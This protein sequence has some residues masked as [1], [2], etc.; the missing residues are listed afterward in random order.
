MFSLSRPP[1][2]GVCTV[3]LERP[4]ANAIGEADLDGL[5][6]LLEDLA[7]DERCAVLVFTGTGRFFSAGADI[8]LMAQAGPGA[9]ERLTRLAVEMQAAYDAIERL[10]FPTIAAINGIATGGGLELALACDLRIAALSASIGLTETRIGL[11]P[12]AGGTQRLVQAAGRANALRL[13]LRGE[14][15]DGAEAARLGIVQEAVPAEG[16]AARA[17]ALAEELAA[18]PREALR[19]AKRCIA[20]APSAAGYAAEIEETRRLHACEETRGRIAA[21]LA[22]RK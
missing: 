22:R 17:Q 6:S 12:G 1:S 3:T 20:L 11:I 8:K 14:I 15:V 4:P 7:S 2:S 5:R 9:V 19:S 13:I 16:L 21:F 18:Q 10:P